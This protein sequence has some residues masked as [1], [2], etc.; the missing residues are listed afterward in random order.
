MLLSKLR[1]LLRPK[2]VAFKSAR[3]GGGGGHGM[4]NVSP[5]IWTERFSY[6][7]IHFY[8]CLGFIPL[9]LLGTYWSVFIGDAILQDIPEGY[10]P[11]DWECERNPGQRL[12]ARYY[13]P[14]RQ[15]GLLFC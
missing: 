12:M 2:L 6:D 4:M 1:P 9:L 3:N 8:S 11:E 10:E 15:I 13:L 7:K 14:G 5:T